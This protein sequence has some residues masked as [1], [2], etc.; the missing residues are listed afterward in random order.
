MEGFLVVGIILGFVIFLIISGSYLLSK[1]VLK[2]T[3]DKE[4][5]LNRL[6][7]KMGI[8]GIA[9][10][11]GLLFTIFS[12]S[13]YTEFTII[14]GKDISNWI[15]LA[16]EIAIGITIAILILIY[17]QFREEKMT[18]EL[19]GSIKKS[20]EEITTFYTDAP[21][22]N[23]PSFGE[24]I[25]IPEQHKIQKLP[26]KDELKKKEENETVNE[27]HKKSQENKLFDSSFMNELSSN[28]FV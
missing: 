24:D 8:V 11:G 4:L 2:K 15:T 6:K 19:S 9:T 25:T 20:T 3:N 18:S 1:H 12:I 16:V 13:S 7:Y 26:N 21:E 5:E 17:S 14:N 22:E 28:V 23:N 10:F 27:V